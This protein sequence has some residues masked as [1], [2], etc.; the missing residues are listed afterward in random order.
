MARCI[1]V[2][3]NFTQKV[4]FDNF[5]IIRKCCR[6]HRPR[7]LYPSIDEKGFIKSSDYKQTISQLLNKEV[8]NKT[9]VMTSLNRYERKKNIPLALEA[10]AYYLKNADENSSFST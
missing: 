9:V 8:T 4:F 7:V 5:P 1:V 2:N 3:S 10:F 6:N